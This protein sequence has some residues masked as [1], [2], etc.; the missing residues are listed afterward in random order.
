[1]KNNSLGRILIGLFTLSIATAG[2]VLATVSGPKPLAS[3]PQCSSG[4]GCPGSTC[5]CEFNQASGKYQCVPS[6]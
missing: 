2:T 6:N 1:M 3:C 4:L 5:S